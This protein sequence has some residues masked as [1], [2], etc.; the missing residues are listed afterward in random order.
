MTQGEYFFSLLDTVG[1]RK[2]PFKEAWKRMSSDAR[3]FRDCVD[4]F[5]LGRIW[6]F[7]GTPELKKKRQIWAERLYGFFTEDQETVQNQ[8]LDMV[9]ILSPDR[10][11]IMLTE[12]IEN[13]DVL[14]HPWF[15]KLFGTLTQYH[16]SELS[17]PENLSSFMFRVSGSR[18]FPTDMIEQFLPEIIEARRTREER[19]SSMP[20]AQL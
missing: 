8:V 6:N 7:Y 12:L 16:R 17:S 19:L 13:S 10:Q 4:V 18:L 11:V 15:G 9:T 1:L 3:T 20:Q 5:S 2:D 14:E